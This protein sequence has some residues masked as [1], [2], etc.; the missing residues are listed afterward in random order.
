MS[1]R[2]L[3]FLRNEA[4]EEATASRIRQFEAATG[5]ADS[6]QVPIKMVVELILGLD[7][8]VGRD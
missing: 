8:H 5:K 1:G 2:P 3:K 6:F 4:I 7:F